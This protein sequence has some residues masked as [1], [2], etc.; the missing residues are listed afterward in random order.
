MSVGYMRLDR[1]VVERRNSFRISSP[2]VKRCYWVRSSQNYSPRIS[3]LS[4][5][6]TCFFGLNIAT[7]GW[8]KELILRLVL[9][10]LLKFSIII[11]NKRVNFYSKNS[12]CKFSSKY[13]SQ[14]QCYNLLWSFMIHHRLFPYL[15]QL[16]WVPDLKTFKF[17]YNVK[18]FPVK[19]HFLI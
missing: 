19:F 6:H 13:M 3:A 7:K 1:F 12:V 2:V 8:I 5:L 10:I 14:H 4:N 16:L 9:T 18:R 15:V 11:F 17:L